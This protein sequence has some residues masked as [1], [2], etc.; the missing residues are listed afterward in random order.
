MCKKVFFN[1]YLHLFYL[2]FNTL[3][4][5]ILT[6]FNLFMYTE[7]VFSKNWKLPINLNQQWHFTHY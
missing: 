1:S 7:D 6:Y 3:T 5:S 4:L 2:S